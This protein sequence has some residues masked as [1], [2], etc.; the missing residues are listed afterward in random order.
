T[1]QCP[2]EETGQS[3]K[4]AE[5]I[6]NFTRA[7]TDVAGRDIHI[8]SDMPKLAVHER[9]AETHDFRLTLSLRIKVAAALTATE[10]LPSQCIL[11]YLFK[12]QELQ[13]AQVDRRMESQPAFVRADR[14]GKANTPGAVDLDFVVIV[15]PCNAKRVNA[16]RFGESFEYRCLDPFRMFIKHRGKRRNNL[17]H[18]LQ[19]LR[20]MF[21]P[22]LQLGSNI[23]HI[24]RG[25]FARVR[26]ARDTSR[27][28]LT[29]QF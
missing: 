19:E 17:I 25:P 27:P 23:L 7:D 6:S 8:R 10:H 9:L 16:F 22:T 13:D 28:G 1:R 26:N 14:T 24:V 4:L 20:F 5:E 29:H 21:Q 12:S 11:E 18:C 2:V 3:A 15:S